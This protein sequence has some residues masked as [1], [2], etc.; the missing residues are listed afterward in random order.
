M[1]LKYIL[2]TQPHAAEFVH[3]IWFPPHV[4]HP[5]HS[6]LTLF[7][8]YLQTK[9]PTKGQRILNIALRQEWITRINL[10][11]LASRWREVRGYK[12]KNLKKQNTLTN[13][14]LF[15]FWWKTIRNHPISSE[16]GCLPLRFLT[17]WSA[18]TRRML[19]GLTEIQEEFAP[20]IHFGRTVVSFI[21]FSVR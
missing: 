10:E 16:S 19:I 14:T 17:I 13:K 21:F 3:E 7:M 6:P 15:L 12:T 1:S 2:L 18:N 8:S 9:S 5:C 4:S 11:R 20:Q